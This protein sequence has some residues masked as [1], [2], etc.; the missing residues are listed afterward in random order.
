MGGGS[1][2]LPLNITILK[3]KSGN[4]GGGIYN[5]GTLKFLGE[6]AVYNNHATTGADDLYNEEGKHLIFSKVAQNA[7]LDD[8]NDLIDDTNNRWNAHDKEKNYIQKYTGSY[9]TTSKLLLKA[10]HPLKGEV[11]VRYVDE[12]GN[13]LS[14]SDEMTGYV[15]STYQAKSKDIPKY[16]LKSVENNESGVYS[17]E[18]ILVTYI[19]T[20]KKGKLIVRYVDEN[21][22]NLKDEES[23]IGVIDTPYETKALVFSCYIISKEPDNKKGVYTEE[24]SV[25]LYVY[26][27]I[28]TTMQELEFPQ[29]GSKIK[30]YLY[31]SIIIYS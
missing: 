24:D 12:E 8:C 27:K 11:I 6:A 21:G 5:L 4:L 26:T 28:K 23:Y 19:Y 1:L 14:E 15:D 29:T 31:P 30:N 22:N 16:S 2:T 3:N 9:D 10:A 18:N 7:Y 25:F 20:K 13:N 17:K